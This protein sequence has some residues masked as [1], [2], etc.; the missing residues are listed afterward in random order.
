[1]RNYQVWKN[2]Q[3]FGVN[4]EVMVINRLTKEQADEYVARNPDYW[5]VEI[6]L[7]REI[8]EDQFDADA[9]ETF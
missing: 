6:K 2:G 3:R 7:V 1:M 9:K 5:T 8:P 4:Q